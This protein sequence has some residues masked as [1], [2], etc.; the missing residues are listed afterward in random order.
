MDC[1]TLELGIVILVGWLT[2]EI[3]DDMRACV[4]PI[5]IWI[6]WYITELS[7]QVVKVYGL[8]GDD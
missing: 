7:I 3:I 1:D 6:I 4:K 5:H 8:K 2:P